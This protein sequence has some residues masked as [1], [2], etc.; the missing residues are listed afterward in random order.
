MKD[1]NQMEKRCF[2][3]S[4]V[5]TKYQ[6]DNG[7]SL[8]NQRCKCEAYARDHGYT[9]VNYFG[10]KHESA[11]TLGKLIKEMIS[12][13]KKD[14]SVNYILVTEA[15]R[16][17]RNAGQGTTTL[18]NLVSLGVTVVETLTGLD[19]STPQG[20]LMI[21]FKI[22]MSQWDNTNRVDKFISG[23]KHCLET[24]V[25]TGHRPEGYDKQ[26]KSINTTYT[27][28]EKGRLIRKA[29]KWKLEGMTNKDIINRLANYD[30][31][32]SKQTLH[33]ILTNPFYAGKIVNK[34]M[35]YEI[36]DGK[37][38]AIISYEDFL[39]VQ[40]ILSG[41]TGKYVHQKE[42]PQFPLKRHV[43]CAVDGTPFTAYSVKKKH[44][45]YY[46]C[47][48][49]G[50]KTNVSARVMHNKYSELLDTFNI[51]APLTS[52]VRKIV[53]DKI[54]G[55]NTELKETLTMLKKS[56]TELE[57]KIKN[58]KLRFADGVIDEDVYQTALEEN[59]T[60]LNKILLEMEQVKSELSNSDSDV[61]SIVAMCCKL[62]TLWQESSLKTCQK[63][64]NLVFPDGILW[65]KEIGDYRTIKTNEA[66]V[67]ICK[68]SDAYKNIGEG[69][70]LSP[71]ALCGWGDSNPHGFHH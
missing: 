32:I 46:K 53:S 5:S 21:Q 18:N 57:N 11:K 52:I 13:V 40:E 60:K 12:A 42:T 15:D 70:T 22:C 6:E 28:N 36:I 8:D 17:S 58:N 27:I 39:R 43:R 37:H 7:G 26:G 48:K 20:L 16:F 25:F 54:N 59:Q 51:P 24:G 47:N 44:K 38:P 1:N 63:L 65:D 35:N 34:M 10:G 56:K 3:W 2:V 14:R 67:L 31:H 71:V 23:R 30:Y 55:D 4:R 33:K 29:F 45:D 9:I 68:I 50:C 62:G 64:Q 61:D 69:D 66:L 19:T 41:K 49:I